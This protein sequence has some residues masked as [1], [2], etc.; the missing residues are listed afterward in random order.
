MAETNPPQPMDAVG[1]YSLYDGFM[2]TFS[3]WIK[4]LKSAIFLSS[5]IFDKSD[6]FNIT[7]RYIAIAKWHFKFLLT[8]R[9]QLNQSYKTSFKIKSLLWKDN[10]QG[11]N[12]KLD[13]FDYK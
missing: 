13:H 2:L 10:T 12:I 3:P 1:E 8:K 4:M 5:L 11:I 9:L 6:S 7:E